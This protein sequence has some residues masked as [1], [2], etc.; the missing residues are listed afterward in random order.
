[1][2]ALQADCPAANARREQ[3]DHIERRRSAINVVAEEDLKGV[4]DRM[5][6][7][8]FIDLGEGFVQ[9]V[10]SSM[11]VADRIHAR[12]RRQPGAFDFSSLAKGPPH[13]P[14]TSPV[15]S[16]RALQPSAGL[17]FTANEI[18]AG[19]KFARDIARMVRGD[20]A[21]DDYKGGDGLQAWWATSLMRKRLDGLGTLGS[22]KTSCKDQTLEQGA[23][24]VSELEARRANQIRDRDRPDRC[25]LCE[26]V[27]R[28]SNQTQQNHRKQYK[29]PEPQAER[30]PDAQHC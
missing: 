25:T 17:L 26:P 18:E 2:V 12:T 9:Q 5:I 4:G 28:A 24:Q 22:I 6:R 7:A 20:E 16:E 13:F 23:A 14:T 15:I 29:Y 19:L 30:R 1:M 10:G 8:V 21:Q 3:F 11:H 27:S